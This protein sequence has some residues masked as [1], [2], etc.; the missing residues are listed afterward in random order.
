M[1][2]YWVITVLGHVISCVTIQQLTKSERNI[3]EWSQRIRDY[4]IVTE[5]IIDVKDEY[6]SKYLGMVER[7]NNLTVADEDPEFLD[8]YNC[9]I[10]DVSIPNCEDNNGTDY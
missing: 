10:S 1:M 6:L 3:D 8:K 7:W 5:Q 2:S 4:N 9:V